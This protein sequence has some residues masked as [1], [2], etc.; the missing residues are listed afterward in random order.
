MTSSQPQSRDTVYRFMRNSS[1]ASLL[2][3]FRWCKGITVHV[4]HLQ[5]SVP[6][7]TWLS[8]ALPWE[9]AILYVYMYTVHE[10]WLE[11]KVR[12]CP[13]LRSLY[14]PG[15]GCYKTNSPV[16]WQWLVARVSSVKQT[17]RLFVQLLQ[18]TIILLWS[19]LPGGVKDTL[20]NKH[21]ICR[22]KIM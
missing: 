7:F 13:K 18:R 14:P 17:I 10:Y 4:L 19:Q 12:V 8:Q 21:Q 15:Y 2:V 1:A 5:K 16:C 11:K 20:I 6:V 9:A 22:E 3:H